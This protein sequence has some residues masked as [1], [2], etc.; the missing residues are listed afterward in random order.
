MQLPVSNLV[1]Q[2]G[3][4]VVGISKKFHISEEGA[5]EFVKLA[6]INWVK[7]QYKMQISGDI[8]NGPPKLLEKLSE[9]VL[10]W[11]ADDFDDEDFQVIG[12]CKNIR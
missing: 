1:D 8:L 6:I 10:K 9:E 3:P 12:Y 5:S 11:T 2:M 7:T 4:L